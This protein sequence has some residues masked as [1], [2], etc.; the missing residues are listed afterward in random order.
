LQ[1]DFGGVFGREA[2]IEEAAG[3]GAQFPIFRQIAAGLP[4]H[5]DRRHLLPMA[6]KHFDE[7]LWGGFLAQCMVPGII[8][9]QFAPSDTR[10]LP[11][12]QG[13]IWNRTD[14]V[15]LSF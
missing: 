2:E 10:R 3:P 7:R 9:G 13:K 6:R 4:H 5:P 11:L 8:S 15:A 1:R 12:G 14:S